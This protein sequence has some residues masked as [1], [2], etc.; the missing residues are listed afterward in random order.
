[1]ISVD[2]LINSPTLAFPMII[3]TYNNFTYLKNTINFWAARGQEEFVILDNGSTYPP[4][5]NLLNSLKEY[6]VVSSPEN[7]GPRN[8]YQNQKIYHW[9]PNYFIVTDP[10]LEFNSEINMEQ[11]NKLITLTDTLGLFKL[12]SRLN[13]DINAENIVDST[14]LWG[15]RGNTIR[16]LE[17]QYYS[18]CIYVTDDGEPVFSAPIDTTF[19]VYNKKNDAGFFGRSA[20]I[21]GIYMAEH[22][23]WYLNHPV[24]EEE[25]AFYLNSVSSV[26]HASAEVIRRGESW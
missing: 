6:L 5:I 11:I 25:R 24:L 9:L 16:N 3:P 10:D 17:M 14:Y 2:E 8:F 18:S 15:G 20:R 23:G 12:G 13:L 22:L 21:G 26:R 7:P 1:M 4:M 19:A